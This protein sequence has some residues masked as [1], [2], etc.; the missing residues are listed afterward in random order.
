[1]GR[2]LTVLMVDW[3]QLGAIP[4][5]NRIERLDDMAWPWEPDDVDNGGYERARGRLRPPG[6]APA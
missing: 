4:V 1:M 3:G 6:R 2:D 5:E